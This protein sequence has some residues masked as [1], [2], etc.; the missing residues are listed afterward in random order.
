MFTPFLIALFISLGIISTDT[1]I[2]NLS[3]EQTEQINEI[4]INDEIEF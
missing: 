2:N 3:Q 1:D 4:I